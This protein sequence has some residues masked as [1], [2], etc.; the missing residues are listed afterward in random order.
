MN[1]PLPVTR[2]HP[3]GLF[4][5]R[6][7][8]VYRASEPIVVDGNLDKKAW[9]DAPW[10]EPFEDHQAP[11]APPPWRVTRAAMLWDDEHLY[12][13]ARLQEENVWGSITQR[14]AVIYRDNDFEIFLDVDGRGDNY[15]EFEI[16]PL[17]TVWDMFHPREYHRRSCLD[18]AYDID[19]IRHAIQVQGTL[20]NHHDTDTGWT[21][22]VTWPWRS[23][24]E[25]GRT[26]ATIPPARGQSFRVNFSRVQYPHDTTGLS[27]AKVEGARCE[28][29]IWN[30][31]N[32]GDLHIP[33]AWGRVYFSDRVAGTEPE[34][35]IEALAATPALPRPVIADAPE[36][37]MVWIPP[38]RITM[39]PDESSPHTSPAHEVE[40]EGYW[41]DRHPVTVAQFAAF[42]IETSL[43]EHYVEAMANPHECGI[44][45]DGSG[46]YEVVPGR[47]DYPVVYVSHT[48]ALAYAA[49]YDRQLPTE[50][51]WERA[52]RGL[53]GRTYPW[54]QEQPTP[55]HANIDY[56]YGG[57]TSIGSFPLGV[58]D[59]GVWDLAG[60]VKE[61]CLDE[62]HP[63]P[64]GAPMLDFDESTPDLD[65]IQ[66]A[67]LRRQLF[68]VRGG[69]WSKQEANV[70]STYRD[71]DGAGRWFFSLGFRTVK[72]TD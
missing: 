37:D 52:A 55:E 71:A 67:A 66:E 50:A 54:G 68:C 34:D 19:G 22:E 32:C 21:V 18:T 51:Q 26:A 23:I 25:H 15:Y 65:W 49:S 72:L 62:Y 36:R 40:L 31:T 27:C 46:G 29:W 5:P 53:E 28:D 12:F 33:E 6:T 60:N 30:S 10:T 1:R 56:R 7:Y 13:A 20:N 64:G 2:R 38:C 16:N 8:V 59:E 69:G 70:R 63:Y 45:A 61:W 48:V 4:L 14:D 3:K 24:R 17:N 9:W 11:N 35:E 43:D 39:G 41:I 57:T 47:E 58:T 42:L 44:L